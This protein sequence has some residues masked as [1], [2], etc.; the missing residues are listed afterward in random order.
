MIGPA[1]S[2]RTGVALMGGVLMSG[3]SECE[4]IGGSETGIL[5]RDGLLGRVGGGVV[6]ERVG[7]S[8][9]GVRGDDGVLARGRCEI[10]RMS[11]GG[12]PEIDDS[13]KSLRCPV[14]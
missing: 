4:E 1:E 13:L 10:D 9:T 14:P 2:L 3:G 5:G 11:G 7:G 12:G 6:L 8:G